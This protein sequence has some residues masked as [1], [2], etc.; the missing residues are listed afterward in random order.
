M[1]SF[2]LIFSDGGIFSSASRNTFLL[3]PFPPRLALAAAAAAAATWYRARLHPSFL[4]CPVQKFKPERER[5]RESLL[6]S[7]N[8]LSPFLPSVSTAASASSSRKIKYKKKISSLFPSLFFSKNGC[9]NVPGSTRSSIGPTNPL[10]SM[11]CPRK[12]LS[13]SLTH[14]HTHLP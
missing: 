11:S 13:L 7:F 1:R 2:C 10:I 12:N 9:N 4:L 3:L 14:T 6:G 5:E 8:V